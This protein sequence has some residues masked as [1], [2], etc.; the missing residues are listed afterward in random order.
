[1]SSYDHHTSYEGMHIIL[2][3]THFKYTIMSELRGN[4]ILELGGAT[5]TRQIRTSNGRL[6]KLIQT[7]KRLYINTIK[8]GNKCTRMKFS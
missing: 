1:M 6:R 5:V 4:H 3:N 7:F 2:D 8:F